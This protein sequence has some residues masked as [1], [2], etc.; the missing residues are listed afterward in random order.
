MRATLIAAAVAAGVLT[1]PG[2]NP[3]L[4]EDKPIGVL[5][6]AGDIAT[7]VSN[8]VRSGQATADLVQGEIDRVATDLPGVEVQV[9]ALGDLAYE[10]GESMNCFD[11]TWG[12][13]KDRML[14]VPGNHDYETKKGAAYFAYFQSRLMQLNAGKKLGTYAID[15]PSTGDHKWRLI[16]LNS[17]DETGETNGQV[18][19][20]KDEL[21]RLQGKRC[22]LAFAHAF[23]Y[24]SGLHGH[25]DGTGQPQNA[26]A[27]LSK[28]LLPGT[29]LRAMFAALY[30]QR[31]SVFLA[32]HDH[33]FEQLGRAN[34]NASPADR[35]QAAIVADGVRSF[36]VGTGGKGL[37]AH[38][39][40]S[41]WA[42]TEAYDLKRY[43][44]LRI[45][46]YPR[47]YRWQFIPI[48]GQADS[49]TI[50]KRVDGKPIDHDDCNVAE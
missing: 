39:Y 20:L 4:A 1:G 31:A 30:A 27:D 17:N 24:S 40:T 45:D 34:G 33:H 50:L 21:Q 29:H 3:S 38:D 14:P 35:G 19:W 23:F 47:A 9:I 11:K 25:D 46:L 8:K 44:I 2:S 43:G 48:S 13:F 49:M 28:P 10:K 5:L 37:Y 26:V 7:C 42:F 12:K 16:G 6:A 32:G 15:F 36:V 18:T 22:V 41:K